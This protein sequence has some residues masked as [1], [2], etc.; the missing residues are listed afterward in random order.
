V[1]LHPDVATTAADV[2]RER[3]VTI[4]PDEALSRA[5]AVVETDTE[6]VDLRVDSALVRLR[7]VL[8]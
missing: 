8:S 3:G 2:L 5:D 1:R 6:V 4:L 7:E